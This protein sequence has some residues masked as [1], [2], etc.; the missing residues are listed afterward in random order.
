MNR[1]QRRKAQALARRKPGPKPAHTARVLGKVLHGGVE[2][3]MGG[4]LVPDG[5]EYA[6]NGTELVPVRTSDLDRA[7]VLVQPPESI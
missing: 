1:H 4:R 7:W 5:I 2:V 6:W 3:R